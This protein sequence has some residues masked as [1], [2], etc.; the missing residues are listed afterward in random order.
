MRK[1]LKNLCK[2]GNLSAKICLDHFE[3]VSN[4]KGVKRMKLHVLKRAAVG[5]H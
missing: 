4:L 5:I 3:K 2:R 1:T